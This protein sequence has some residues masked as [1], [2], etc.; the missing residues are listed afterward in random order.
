MPRARGDGKRAARAGAFEGPGAVAV[1]L[2][3]PRR[4]LSQSG[5]AY[6]QAQRTGTSGPPPIA[7]SAAAAAGVRC[8]DVLDGPPPTTATGPATLRARGRR[9]RRPGVAS[10]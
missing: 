1:T 4:G 10:R 3:W 7:P 5:P 9:R 8:S 2:R 6:A